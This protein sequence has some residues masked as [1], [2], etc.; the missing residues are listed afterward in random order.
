MPEGFAFPVNH[1]FWTPLKADPSDNERG[2]G[3]SIYISGRLAPGVDLDDA[4]AELTVI[5]NR[6][7]AEFPD[8]HKHLRPEVLPY[9]YPVR[10]HE[11]GIR[12]RRSGR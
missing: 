6:M 12:G 9:T 4:Q 3:P 1:R 10:R 2:E 8:T 7:A 5:G 11:Q